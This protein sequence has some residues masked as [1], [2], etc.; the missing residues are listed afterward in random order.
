VE[1]PF[2][3][4][5]QQLIKGNTWPDLGAFTAALAHFSAELD[6]QVHGTTRE[7]PMDRFAAETAALLPLPAQS[8]VGT[9]QALRLVSWDCLISYGG[10]RYSVPWQHAGSRVWVKAR[11]GSEL[12][13]TSQAGEEVARHAVPTT[14][15]TTVIDRT[16]YAGLR[17]GLPTTKRRVIEVF[18]ERFPDHG[19]FVQGL[20]AQYPASGAAPLRAVLGLVELYPREALLAAF[21]A[22]RQYHAYTHTFLRGV[23]QQQAVPEPITSGG[24]SGRWTAGAAGDALTSDLAPYQQLLEAVG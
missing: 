8:F 15:G 11:Q 18:L 24:S 23:L 16:H 19:W 14:C 2:S 6:T 13:V 1:R 7:R 9:Y 21:A 20:Y 5:E 10:T 22:A 17:Q 12:I 4:L 3:H